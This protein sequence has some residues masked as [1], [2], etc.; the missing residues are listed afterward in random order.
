MRELRKIVPLIAIL[1][2][3]IS[4]SQQKKP[5]LRILQIGDSN[6]E[7]GNITMA[8]K[9]LLDNEFG[10][11]GTGYCTLNPNSMGR[12]PDSL[13]VQCDS[14]W[15]VSDMR[16]D[17]RPEQPPYYSPDGL[18]ISSSVAGAVTTVSFSGSGMDLYYLQHPG[19][20]VFSVEI[21]GMGKEIVKENGSIY[22]TKKLSYEKLPDGKQSLKIKVVSGKV[23]LLGIDTKNKNWENSKRYIL[24]KWG[25]GWAAT[26]DYLNI[27]KKVFST[28]LQELDP[29]KIV[30]LLGTNDY[31]LDRRNPADFK[32]NL[33]EL[34][35]R[36]KEK[37]PDVEV[38]IVSTFSTDGEE[39]KTIL[40]LYVSKSFPEA[41][42]ETNSTYWDMNTWF[43]PWDREKLPDG[44]HVNE[45]YGKLIAAEL[46]K[47]LK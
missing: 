3:S 18:S 4:C 9:T 41:A 8:L 45:A 27:D 32:F 15:I 23:I 46:F 30:I 47:R 28:A 29:N 31:G 14:N 7:I 43:G 20:G 33:K 12:V 16:N 38:L 42:I 40:P 34:I 24:H 11:Y 2:I 6:T 44:V 17:V 39:S 36:I 13:S 1:V 5:S 10:N 26:S 22:S 37:L 21:D 35:S 19:G 25:N